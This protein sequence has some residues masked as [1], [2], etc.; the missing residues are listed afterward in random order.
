[1]SEIFQN[2]ECLIIKHMQKIIAFGI[3]FLRIYFVVYGTK[4]ELKEI[5]SNKKPKQICWRLT[6]PIQLFILL[7][8]A[9][10][11]REREAER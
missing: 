11:G 7:S 4:M 3:A 8:H 9:A 5:S 10:V 6:K 2:S 1:M